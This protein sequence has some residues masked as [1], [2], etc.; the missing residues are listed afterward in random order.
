GELPPE[1]V[2]G[3]PA[4][5]ARIYAARGCAGCHMVTGQGQG[6][7][8]ELTA[9][10][11]RR[12]AAFL[13]QTILKPAATLPDGFLLVA[14]VSASG[15]AVPGIRVNEDSCTTQFPEAAS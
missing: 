12:S 2:P 8:P 4:R 9:I 1:T 14:A 6:Y 11:A 13:R 5:G 3:D 7:G 10:G 15:N